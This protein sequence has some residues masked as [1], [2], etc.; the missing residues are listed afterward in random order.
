MLFRSGQR[1][2]PEVLEVRWRGFSIADVLSQTVDEA[3][4]HF[5]HQPDAARILESLQAVGLGYLGLGQSATTLSG[6][7]AQRL[8]LAAELHRARQGVRSVLILDEPSTGLAGS[9]LV[10]LARTLRRLAL[11]GNAVV[12][13][14]HQ[15]DLLN[16]CDRLVELGP[17]GGTEG[18]QL[19][20]QGT[21][22]ELAANTKSITG[23]FLAPKGAVKKPKRARKKVRK[24]R[25]AKA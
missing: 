9:D 2:R 6:G 24:A 10:H 12:I 23:P 25:G 3:A 20:A 17:A 7:E 1:F 19:H 22:A 4:A 5:A 8:K 15:T 18:G 11:R 14:E 13:I 21:P 16:I